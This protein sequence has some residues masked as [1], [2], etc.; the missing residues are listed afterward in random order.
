MIKNMI[1]PFSD[2]IPKDT[3]PMFFFDV[4]LFC[5]CRCCCCNRSS[6]SRELNSDEKKRDRERYKD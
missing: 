6:R 2:T 3:V 4:R 1:T 5:S